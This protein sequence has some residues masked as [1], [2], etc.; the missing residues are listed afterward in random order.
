MRLFC[1][2]LALHTSLVSD[3]LLLVHYFAQPYRNRH[4]LNEDEYQDLTQEGTIGLIR[5]AEKFDSS[6][7]IKFTTY[8]SYWIRSHLQ[9][10]MKRYYRHKYVSLDSTLMQDFGKPDIIP[11]VNVES[12]SEQDQFLIYLRYTRGKTFLEI[13]NLLGVTQH[14]AIRRHKKILQTLRKEC[15]L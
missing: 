5:A 6:K 15:F 13:S 2:L 10:Y 4:S 9:K 11:E 7:N 8:S 1:M 3:N 14:T 12:L